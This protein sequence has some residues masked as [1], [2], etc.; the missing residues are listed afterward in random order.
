MELP[1]KR[2]SYRTYPSTTPLRGAVPLP[3]TSSGRICNHPTSEAK[4]LSAPVGRVRMRSIT[5][6]MWPALVPQA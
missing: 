6:A 2:E 1:L 3:E 4:V 5:V